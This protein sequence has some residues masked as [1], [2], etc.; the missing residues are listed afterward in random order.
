MAR[1]SAR[2][3]P[4]AGAA[5]ESSSPPRRTLVIACQGGGALTAFQAGVLKALLASAA[6][7]A[8]AQ[9]QRW[10]ELS[11]L[12]GPGFSAD[13]D[14]KD[15]SKQKFRLVG[16]SGTSGGAQNAAIAWAACAV[17]KPEDVARRLDDWWR[18]IALPGGPALPFDPASLVGP[19]WPFV[20][21]SRLLRQPIG[22]WLTQAWLHWAPLLALD[23]SWW[24]NPFSEA[25]Q[26]AFAD[27]L[28]EKL[29]R[30]LDAANKSPS[31]AEMSVFLG[32]VEV[33][34]GTFTVFHAGNAATAA[35]VGKT[36][37]SRKGIEH[38]PLQP[39]HLVASACLPEVFGS[40]RVAWQAGSAVSPPRKDGDFW[41]GLYSHNPPLGALLSFRPGQHGEEAWHPDVVLVLRVNP[42][43]TPEI[44]DSKSEIEDRH[45]ELIGNLS[46]DQEIH[47]IDRINEL[48]LKGKAHGEGPYANKKIRL[49]AAAAAYYGLTEIFELEPAPDHARQWTPLS[50]ANNL[51]W[52]IRAL[53][54]NGEADGKAAIAAP[55][56]FRRVT[57]LPRNFL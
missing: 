21:P 41:D 18:A 46:L 1:A 55:D 12:L 2:P 16:F 54:A 57:P 27:L 24:G 37:L 14:D 36:A 48:V 52:H 29:G 22:G 45:N 42:R 34:S 33:R 3:E 40:V 49:E 10:V 25:L 13:P 32:A 53:L 4:D 5:S 39:E 38:G 23:S 7:K 26:A 11:L 35:A 56:R 6:Y 20:M 17:G 43:E 47:A 31:V 51:D 8:N 28:R 19:G 15:R 44:P 9:G 30:G 50:K